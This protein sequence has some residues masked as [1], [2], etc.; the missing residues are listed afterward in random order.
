MDFIY[1]SLQ[2]NENLYSVI[3]KSLYQAKM[4]PKDE[5]IERSWTFISMK[6]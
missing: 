6:K 3:S 5:M 2:E 1:F 4:R